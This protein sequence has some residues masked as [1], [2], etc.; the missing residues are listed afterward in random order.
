VSFIVI[1]SIALI[2]AVLAGLTLGRQEKGRPGPAAGHRAKPP[3]P[4]CG[5]ALEGKERLHSRVYE[6][7]QEQLIHLLGCPYC[8]PVREG[9]VRRCPVCQ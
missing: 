6:G 8:Y 7:P 9:V 4:L 3:C 2:L 1:I 5:A